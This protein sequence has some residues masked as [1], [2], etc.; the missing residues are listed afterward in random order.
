M[1]VGGSSS[2]IKWLTFLKAFKCFVSFV[3]FTEGSHK[4]A[5][6]AHG[7]GDGQDRIQALKYCTKQ[8]HFSDMHIHW[9]IAQVSA[10]WSETLPVIVAK[11]L[12]LG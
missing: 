4:W 8:Q 3:F 5:F 7:S 9:Q 10:K 12:H 1:P 2:L 11:S 6:E